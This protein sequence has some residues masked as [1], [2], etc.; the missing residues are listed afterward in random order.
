MEQ[1]LTT[2]FNRV[3]KLGQEQK[4]EE[5]QLGVT[6]NWDS[7][8]HLDLI[9]SIEN[10]FNIVFTG[11]EIADMTSGPAILEAVSGKIQA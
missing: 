5:L 1:K 7:L 3:L 10:E 4:L 2:I 6:P 9:L 8:T 11:D